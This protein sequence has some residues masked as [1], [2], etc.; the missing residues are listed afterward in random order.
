MSISE[1]F[2]GQSVISSRLDTEDSASASARPG[3]G[4][5]GGDDGADTFLT[6]LSLSTAV[7]YE[8]RGVRWVKCTVV[9]LY[10]HLSVLAV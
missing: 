7:R 1:Y 2:E 10:L 9:I 4:G 8:G 3:S 6:L 5:C